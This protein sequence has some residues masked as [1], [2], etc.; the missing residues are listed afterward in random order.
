MKPYKEGTP[1]EEI[2][3]DGWS[4]GF[5]YEQ[6]LYEA[7][8]MGYELSKARLVRE[9]DRLEFQMKVYFENQGC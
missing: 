2:I 9:W 1:L 8:E 6:T 5:R 4:R 7:K 3:K